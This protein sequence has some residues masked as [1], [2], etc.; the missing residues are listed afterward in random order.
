MDRDRLLSP[1]EWLVW[2]H[3]ERNVP[4]SNGPGRGP[5]PPPEPA[6]L[7]KARWLAVR[8]GQR[9]PMLGEDVPWEVCAHGSELCDCHRP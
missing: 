2:R 3:R 1:E 5:T 4:V 9:V 7:V 8:T 6:E